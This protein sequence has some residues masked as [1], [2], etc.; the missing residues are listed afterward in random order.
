[1]SN[2]NTTVTIMSSATA[3]VDKMAEDT[4]K[5]AGDA[6]DMVKKVEEVNEISSSN[7]RSVEEI[8]SAAEHL[9]KLT[10]ELNEKLNEF[11]TS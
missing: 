2:I 6:E 7:T 5:M 3:C 1:G 11:K 8:A 9:Y 4:I 10:E